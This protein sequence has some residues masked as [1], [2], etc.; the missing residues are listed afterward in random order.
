MIVRIRSINTL[1]YSLVVFCTTSGFS[2]PEEYFPLP[3]RSGFEQLLSQVQAYQQ[4]ITQS[5]ASDFIIGGRRASESEFPSVVALIDSEGKAYC[6][7]TLITPSIVATAAHCVFDLSQQQSPVYKALLKQQAEWSKESFKREFAP[8]SRD[9]LSRLAKQGLH[10]RINGKNHFNIGSRVSVASSWLSYS[11]SV[12]KLT[13]FKR[14]E[15]SVSANDV[16]D[17]ALIELKQPFSAIQIPALPTRQ[18]VIAIHKGDYLTAVQVGFGLRKDP[19]TIK[20]EASSRKEYKANLASMY[21]DKYMVE[22]PINMVFQGSE[23]FRAG[24]GL[25][26][27]SACFGD[28]GGPTFVQLKNKQWRFF[29]SLSRGVSSTAKCG[30]SDQTIWPDSASEQIKQTTEF[31]DV[32]LSETQK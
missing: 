19:L 5:N 15:F 13:L 14:N 12:A 3:A 6:T 21:D 10:L 16:S 25:P 18:E 4:T 2:Q 9:Y 11:E 24:I 22:L 30:E 1:L 7:G 28:S 17:R 23:G 31:V 8:F 26:G 29:A 27:K 32:W 20:E